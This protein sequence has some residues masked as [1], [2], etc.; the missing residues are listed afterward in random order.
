MNYSGSR[1]TGIELS[2]KLFSKCGSLVFADTGDTSS[3]QSLDQLIT[4]HFSGN[5]RSDRSSL[6]VNLRLHKFVW[7]LGNKGGHDLA[8]IHGTL[9]K[10]NQIRNITFID[11]ITS[12]ADIYTWYLPGTCNLTFSGI[13]FIIKKK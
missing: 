6:S 1:L 13:F 7:S 9:A 4:N 2:L 8:T 3:D 12:S 5:D 11:R 10:Q